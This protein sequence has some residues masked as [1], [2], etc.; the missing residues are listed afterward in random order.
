M[1]SLILLFSLIFT[2]NVFGSFETLC[3]QRDYTKNV[4]TPQGANIKIY[5][6]L[7]RNTNDGADVNGVTHDVITGKAF[8]KDSLAY[9]GKTSLST[10][11]DIHLSLKIDDEKS[12]RAILKA[13]LKENINDEVNQTFYGYFDCDNFIDYFICKDSKESGSIIKIQESNGDYDIQITNT[14]SKSFQSSL[15]LYDW[16][17][18]ESVGA[19]EF[20]N[21]DGKFVM[22]KP[23][24]YNLSKT[25]C[26]EGDL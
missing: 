17:G 26:S 10:I 12:G 4:K 9:T 1:K 21:Q 13:N 15:V 7:Y 18:A 20:I 3:F 23:D 19:D 16:V 5:S 2:Y 8:S 24:V 6:D 25:E 11:Q 14:I 22:L